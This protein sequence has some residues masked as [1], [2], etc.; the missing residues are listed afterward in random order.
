MNTS[1]IYHCLEKYVWDSFY[2]A[3]IFGLFAKIKKYLVFTFL[4]T[5]RN[6]VFYIF[7]LINQDPDEN[8]EHHFTDIAKYELCAKFQQKMLNTMVVGA[9]QNV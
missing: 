2:F 4:C 9:C 3:Q 5:R 8:N 7:L 1:P 6:Q